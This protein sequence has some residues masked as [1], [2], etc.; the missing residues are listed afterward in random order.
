MKK[1]GFISFILLYLCYLVA[2]IFE[3]DIWGNLL[4]PVVTLIAF[5]ITFVS[6]YCK[7]SNVK[8]KVIGLI[9]SLGIL[10]WALADISW[11]IYERILHIDPQEVSFISFLYGLT[12][13]FFLLSLIIYGY[14]VFRKWNTVQLLLNA[15]VMSFVVELIWIC[16][17]HE[18]ISNLNLLQNDRIDAICFLLDVF[19]VIFIVIWYMTIRNGKMPPYLR[20]TALGIIL[21]AVTDLIYLYQ[22]FFTTYEPN[23]IIDAVYELSFVV[24]AISAVIYSNVPRTENVNH[25]YAIGQKNKSYL[26]LIIPAVLIMFKQSSVSEILQFISVILIY[27]MFSNYI[28]NNINKENQLRK[29]HEYSIELEKKVKERTEQLEEKNKILQNLLDQDFITGLKNRRYLLKYLDKKIDSLKEK[30]SIVLLYIDVNRFKMISTM[31]GNY[32]GDMILYEMAERLT[33]LKQKAKNS[34]L[35]SYGNDTFIFAAAGE[36]NN[37]DGYEFSQ[38]AI[39]LCSDIYKIETYQIKVTV[40]IGISLYPIDASSKEEL[41]KHADMAMMQARHQTFNYVR[42]FDANLS[43]VIFRRNIIEFMLKKANFNQE[44]MIY[45]Q[46]QLLTENKQLIGFEALLRWKTPAGEMIGP[47]EFIPVAEETGYIIPIG[48]W[49]MTGA[50]KQLM[51]WNKR[52]QE[53]IMVGINV[54]LKQLNSTGFMDKLIQKIDEFNIDPEWIDLEITESQQL[55]DN[56]EILNMLEDIR[57]LGIKISIDDFGTGFS[58]LSY[59][60]SLP[61]DRIKIAKELVD[62]IHINDF[63]YKLAEAIILLSKAKGIRV[64]AEG[65]ETR[66]QWEVLK[67]LSCDEVQGYYFGRPEPVGTIEKV[68]EPVMKNYGAE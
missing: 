2:T 51:E 56:P 23:S 6:F 58:S 55:H 60:R 59:F 19:I 38:E 36:Y 22:L 39:R 48:D 13:L 8:A 1:A 27:N 25:R 35:T 29:E 24:I 57:K 16:F 45:F 67:Q 62:Y 17:L 46:P 10:S 63:D 47:G 9:L 5:V 31:Y 65:V 66:E 33:T 34:I 52:F 37:K 15:I 18:R 64:I 50:M 41:I 49:V 30:E 21:Y 4:S 3:S 68:F 61:V 53:K 7:E 40:N 32:V 44:F 42:E 54:S 14:Y 26:L 43:E 20:L 28:Q 12:N 11:A